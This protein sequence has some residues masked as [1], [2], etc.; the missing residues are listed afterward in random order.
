MMK[1]IQ[2]GSSI[3]STKLTYSLHHCM[4]ITNSTSISNKGLMALKLGLVTYYLL[5]PLLLHELVLVSLNRHT[6]T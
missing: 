2:Y 1:P 6:V 3:R 5:L 4:C